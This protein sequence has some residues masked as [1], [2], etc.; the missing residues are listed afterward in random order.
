MRAALSVL[1]ASVM[2]YAVLG[3]SASAGDLSYTA[4]GGE[5]LN[6][7]VANATQQQ[8]KLFDNG[9]LIVVAAVVD[10]KL[11][12]EKFDWPFE[13]VP[14]EPEPQPGPP[15]PHPNSVTSLIWIEESESRS[16][17]VAAALVD[18]NLRQQLSQKKMGF[19]VVDVDVVDENGETPGDLRP[20][21]VAAKAKGLPT[22]F[23]LD[24]EGRTVL[25]ARITSGEQL[26]ELVKRLT[27][28]SNQGQEQKPTTPPPVQTQPAA[29]QE[30]NAKSACPSGSCRTYQPI[31]RFRR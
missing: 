20:L 14:P 22:V 9:R 24:S 5:S 27:G 13:P 7:T 2:L 31:F 12:V 11:V 8:W 18:L 4:A 25:E 21:I 3:A 30:S 1:A 10:N 6:V 16:A 23:G 17:D 19:R 26:R 29:T 28:A 15:T